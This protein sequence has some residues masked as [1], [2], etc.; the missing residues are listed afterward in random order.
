MTDFLLRWAKTSHVGYGRT[1]DD[2]IGWPPALTL[3]TDMVI[4]TDDESVEETRD[5]AD[6]EAMA[7][8]EA[9]A[10]T[11]DGASSHSHY[12]DPD[13]GCRVD[14][15]TVLAGTGRVCAPRISSSSSASVDEGLPV[16]K[17]KI[18]GV[19][20][21]ASNGCPSTRATAA[22]DGTQRAAAWPVCLAKGNTTDPYSAGNFHC[23]LVC[24]CKTAANDCGAAAHAHCPGKARCERGEL[25][26]RAQ[27][28]CTYHGEN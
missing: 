9:T 14:E 28:V 4:R 26:N 21:D 25:R 22:A 27:G 8:L 7:A 20:R 18:G 1:T 16:P 6:A 19:T 3:L 11:A 2:P 5:D 24:P 23:L 10:I 12:G 13:K 17:C 15:D